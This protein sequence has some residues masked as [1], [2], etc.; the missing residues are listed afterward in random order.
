MRVA[1]V[2]LCPEMGTGQA[3]ELAARIAAQTHS[4]PSGYL[5]ASAMA[6]L[7][8]GLLDGLDAVDAVSRALDLARRWPDADETITVVE[9]ALTLAA[10]SDADRARA[11][12]QLGEGWVGEEALAGTEYSDAVR[13]E[14]N[15]G[16]DSD[17]TAA[18]AG[19]IYGAW[20]GQT[21]IS[22]EWIRRLDALDAILNVAGRM[23][24]ART[25]ALAA[26]TIR[27]YEKRR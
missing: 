27:G 9:H 7:V 2:G 24:G 5:S 15:H 21:E 22:D 19:Q 14:S 25:L 8:R 26:E 11:V 13:I 17:S 6:S 10:Q 4:H 18:I 1:P 23:I 16:G 12:G 20:K 3:F